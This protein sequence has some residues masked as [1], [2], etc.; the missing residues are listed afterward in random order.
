MMKLLW[1]VLFKVPKGNHNLYRQ[2]GQ[3]FKTFFG[4]KALLGVRSL[5]RGVSRSLSI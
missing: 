1:K 5:G 4:K 2:S 3:S